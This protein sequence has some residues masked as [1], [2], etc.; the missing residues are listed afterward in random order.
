MF[1]VPGSFVPYND[2]VT[3]LNYK[4]LRDL[5]LDID[6][7]CFK[8]KEDESLKREL[9]KDEEWKKFHLIYTSDF[10]WAVPRNYPY[11]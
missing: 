9:E 4:R 10:D 8:T 1:V 11:R 7:F 2:T 3:L 5:D 6:V